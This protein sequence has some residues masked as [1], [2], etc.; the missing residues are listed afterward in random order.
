MRG[1][2]AEGVATTAKHFVAND[3]EFERHTID[4]VVDER[5]LREIYLVPFELAV[6][7]GETLGIMTGYN[8]LNGTY[9]SEHRELLTQI[10]RKEWGFQG[11]VV[12]D[13]LS[14]GST[15]E[16]AEAG[17]DLQMP[18]PGRF[19]GSALADAVR[20]GEVE[21][22]VVD[23]PLQALRERLGDGVEIVHERG[24]WTERTTP[25]IAA[26]E[27]L[28]S[29]GKAG[30]EIAFFANLDGS[31]EPV[32]RISGS[33]SK[34]LYFGAPATNVPAAGFSFR[35]VG[36]FTPTQSGVH[37]F[38]LMQAGRARLLIDGEVVLD[39]VASPPPRGTA[40]FGMG[41]EEVEA[42]VELRAGEA[43][44]LEIYY[45]AQDSVFLQ[46]VVIGHKPPLE[47]D[48]LESA[49]A[50]AANA[51]AVVIVVGTNDDWESEG[52][53]RE[54]MNL[55]GDQDELVR[56]VCAVNSRTVVCVN[57]GSPVTMEWADEPAA[58]LQIWFGGQ[59]MANALIDVLLGDA[60]PGGRLPTTFPLR[61]E[62]NP[63]FGNFPGENSEIRYG[64][65][66]LV[67]YRWYDTRQLPVRFPFGYGLSYT[68]FEIGSPRLSA[69]SHGPGDLLRVEV[70]VTNTG[71]RVGTE[72]VQCYVAGPAS[73]L[74]RPRRELRAFAKVEL[75]PGECRDVTLLLDNRS[76]AYWDPGDTI[77]EALLERPGG[78]P[79]VVPTGG[80]LAHRSEAG[81]YVD[82]GRHELHLGRSSAD[83]SRVC[84]VEVRDEI[85]P[86][87]R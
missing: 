6:K 49:V 12:S 5:P 3:A 30:L 37:S 68:T 34:L 29:S 13:W 31:G 73:R 71:P 55:P 53:D 80:G 87:A 15:K 9:C 75:S 57:S 25:A 45:T 22:S 48:M 60:E 46:G 41:S 4:S 67:G 52:E 8:R 69:D 44:D 54:S 10:L 78:A 74:F 42:Q 64:E 40:F 51:D 47:D 43:V 18:G 66:L 14:A 85:G 39:G 19:F 24:C 84:Q 11:F 7:E 56:R 16:S 81:W 63:S 17:L 26:S 36:R 86:L 33:D 35:A 23:T 27:I 50:A 28:A 83:T 82:A 77:F 59:E 2:Q 79:R 1:V 32:R 76:F 72:V 58:L 70:P 65:G 21:E 62:H 38:T 61:L 20:A